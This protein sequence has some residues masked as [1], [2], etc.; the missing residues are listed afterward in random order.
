MAV[1]GSAGRRHRRI[2]PKLQRRDTPA[3]PETAF[4]REDIPRLA[5]AALRAF[6]NL[7]TA[8]DL[9][10]DDQCR[11]LGQP[12]RATFYRWRQGQIGGVTPDVLERL[13]HLLAIFGVLQQV[14]NDPAQADAWLRRPNPAPVFGGRTALDR[15][16]QGRIADLLDVRRYVEGILAHGA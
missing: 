12:A 11:L 3:E 5:P 2:R 9:S 6:V 4:R 8:W 16:R 14:F 15:L 1:T 10:T 13:S 7:A